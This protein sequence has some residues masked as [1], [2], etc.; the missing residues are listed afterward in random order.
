MIAMRCAALFDGS[1]LVEEAATVVIDGRT[2]VGVEPGHPDVGADVEVIDL[3]EATVLPGLID[4]HVHLV[5]DS[6]PNALDLVEGYSEQEID[7]VVSRSLAAQLAAGV[8]TV[9]DLGDRRF[10][11]VDRRDRQRRGSTIPEP[12]I[13][14]SGPPLTSPRGHCWYLGGEVDGPTEIEL[15]LA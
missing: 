5:T 4:T 8:T 1:T 7:A 13:L 12:T 6:R 9:R 3:G 2:I 15:A 10:V 11:V 14:A